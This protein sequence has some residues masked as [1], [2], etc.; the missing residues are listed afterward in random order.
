[1]LRHKHHDYDKVRRLVK[2]KKENHENNLKKNVKSFY[3][4]SLELF[5]NLEGNRF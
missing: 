4:K 1:M 2:I 5:Y 3:R